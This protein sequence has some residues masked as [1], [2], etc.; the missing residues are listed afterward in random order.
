MSPRNAPP[1]D[2]EVAGLQVAVRALRQAVE[3]HT[4][5][6]AEVRED[7]QRL[8][9]ELNGVLPRLEAMG[10]RLLDQLDAHQTVEREYFEK[11]RVHDQE[12]ET[13]FR[14]VGQKAE[15]A[16]TQAAHRRLWWALRWF[17]VGT[18]GT[19]LGLLLLKLFGG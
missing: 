16:A 2:A 18:L 17:G 14:V 5:S 3:S 6:L 10:Q 11:V 12:L 8:R 13:L 1:L 19:L 7:F 15:A 9:G 4:A